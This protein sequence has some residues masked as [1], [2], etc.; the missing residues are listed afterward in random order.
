MGRITSF[1]DDVCSRSRT[2]E[3]SQVVAAMLGLTGPIAIGALIGHAEMGMAAALGGVALSGEGKGL[4]TAERALSLLRT[5][6]A[7]TAAMV[8]GVAISGHGMW[9]IFGLPALAMVAGL[10]GRISRPLARASR[11]FVLFT[12]LASGFGANGAHPFGVAFFFF[13]GAIWTA[14]LSLVLRPSSH[15]LFS[16]SSHTELDEA[17]RPPQKT[18]RQLLHHWWN[19]LADLAGWQYPLRIFICLLAAQ[20][21]ELLWP[22]SHSYWIGLTVGIVVQSDLQS[23]LN[24]TLHRAIGTLLGVLITGLMLLEALPLWAIIAIVAVLAA[25]RPVLRDSNYIAYATV[26]TPLIILLLDFGHAPSLAV[27]VNRFV[28]TVAGCAISMILGYFL[29]LRILALR[30]S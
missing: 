25:A 6:V 8:T 10:L 26:H 20:A 12:I 13:L 11:Q 17:A 3:A 7:G 4:T 14:S 16:L 5:L 18:L 30:P 19:S 1:L 9:T 23:S 2:V 15:A 27:S 22:F 24:R 28:A 21:L 29:W